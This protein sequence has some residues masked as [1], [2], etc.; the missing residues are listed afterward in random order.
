LKPP[1]KKTFT[2]KVAK[3]G[4]KDAKKAF[5]RQGHEGGHEGE[6]G[7]LHQLIGYYDFTGVIYVTASM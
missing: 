5:D 7:R 4:A 2:A 1:Y 3:K 6:S